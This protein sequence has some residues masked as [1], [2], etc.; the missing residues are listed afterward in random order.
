M[1]PLLPEARGG[2]TKKGGQIAHLPPTTCSA[3]RKALQIRENCISL[4]RK[5]S[6][7]FLTGPG[8]GWTAKDGAPAQMGETAEFEKLNTLEARLAAA[9]DR[10]AI[11]LGEAVIT[12][13]LEDPGFTSGDYEDA[14]I[15]AQ[16]AEARLAA[17][18]ARLAEAAM[19]S[20]SPDLATLEAERDAARAQL[21]AQ[22]AAR[23]ADRDEAAR[24]LAAR[25][26]ELA[27]LQAALSEAEAKIATP[28]LASTSIEMAALKAR[29]DDLEA[30]L[31]QSH[32]ERDAAR[33]AA[34]Q[35]KSA[36]A[37]S[38]ADAEGLAL[39]AEIKDLQA[40][41]ERLIANMNQLRGVTAT[42]PAVLNAALV[43]ELDALRAMRASEAAELERI[44]VDLDRAAAGEGADA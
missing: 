26:V 40:V 22:D 12:P 42:D 31:V 41:N 30:R 23:Q 35:A 3:A 7:H 13:P 32:A 44:L 37:Q 10:I 24:A 2:A 14:L 5:N 36:A 25:E 28:P 11:G 6:S 43:T 18:E 33:S 1:R 21:Q 8:P 17:L 38:K 29:I 15:R 9:L 19:A 20:P 39:R 4:A 16:T 27:R 34:E